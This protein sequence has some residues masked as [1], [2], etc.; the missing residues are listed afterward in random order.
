VVSDADGAKLLLVGQAAQSKE[1]G[2]TRN[3]PTGHGT[4]AVRASLAMKPSGQREHADM[5]SRG[6]MLCAGHWM[7]EESCSD[8]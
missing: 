7:Q 1:S 5:L 2:P 3:V 8:V 6:W 4:H